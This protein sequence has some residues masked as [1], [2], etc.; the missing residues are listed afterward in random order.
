MSNRDRHIYINKLK[1]TN[2]TLKTTVVNLTQN[3]ADSKKISQYMIQI[4]E[5]EL[6]IEKLNSLD[7]AHKSE[8]QTYVQNCIDYI[9]EIVHGDDNV[10]HKIMEY[11]MLEHFYDLDI[12]LHEKVFDNDVIKIAHIC[13][14]CEITK[15]Y[16]ELSGE[17]EKSS[18]NWTVRK[19][20]LN[21]SIIDMVI[22]NKSEV[23]DSSCMNMIC[24]KF[25][26]NELCRYN[27]K[28]TITSE[29]K[30]VIITM[31]KRTIKILNF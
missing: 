11:V 7:S 19:V 2:E 18:S 14:I 4:E 16:N 29:F 31:N 17:V 6:E 30:K 13:K 22:L 12:Y 20:N 3:N 8:K 24:I 23:D 27:T 28:F 26:F 1:V 10:I 21:N 9:C 25:P 5:N 15:I